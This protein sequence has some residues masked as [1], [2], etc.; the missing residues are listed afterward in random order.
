MGNGQ[1]VELLSPAGNVEGFY[2]AVHAGADAVYLAGERFGARAYARNFTTSE[3]VECIRYGHL[4]GRKIYLT[5]NTLLKDQ[6]LDGLY[7]Y[8]RPVC[9]AG[10]DAVIVQ[11]IGVLRFVR[12]HFPGCKIHVSTQM[13]LCSGF[14]ASLLKSMGACRIVPARELCLQELV[15]LKRKAEVEVEAFV[16]GAMCYCY[17]GQCLFSSVLGARSGNRGR[18]AQPCRLPY[19]V[20]SKGGGKGGCYPLSLKD[21][22]TIEHLP[23]LIESGIDSFKIEGRMKKPEYTAGVTALYR[24]YIDRYYELRNKEGRR[25][26]AAAFR[27]AG[28]DMEALR[29]LYIRSEIQDGYYFRKGGREMITLDNPAYRGSDEE[30]LREIRRKYI[31]APLKLPVTL[32]AVFRTGHPA[33]VDMDWQDVRVSV[34]GLP[35]EKA[36][37]QPVSGENIRTQLGKLGDS[38]FYASDIKVSVDGDCFYPLKQMNELRRVAAAELEARILA[39]RGYRPADYRPAAGGQKPCSGKCRESL[40]PSRQ[41]SGHAFSVLTLPQ[42]EALLDWLRAHPV[43]GCPRIYIDGDLCLEERERVMDLARGNGGQSAFYAALPY[44]VREAEGGYLEKLCSLAEE[45]GYFEGYLVRSMDGLGFLHERG[46]SMAYRAD[47]GLYLWNRYAVR[48]MQSRLEGFCLPYELN[49]GEQRKLGL[50]CEAFPCEKIVYGRIPMMITAN[51]LLRTG[52]HCAKET[53][54]SRGKGDGRHIV[55]LRDRYGMEFPV[56]ADCKH[57][58]NIIYNSVPLSLH[59]KTDKWKGH[60]DLRMDFT[61]ESPSEVL[62]VLDCFFDGGPFPWEEYTNVYEKRG[63]E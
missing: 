17:S 28:E 7:D 20:S 63:V 24:R 57:C 61:L 52:G 53:G 41:T 30:Q 31:D 29:S 12:E 58:M 48:E 21:M 49:A 45:D 10:V 23:K 44:I 36:Q 1:R 11:D 22:C 54:R 13:T 46:G 15:S 2:G 26:A 47:A 18:C 39:H 50:S 38:P 40:S 56:A 25:E 43:D 6:E 32:T 59:R 8:L 14:G 37:K 55:T 3:L 34:C 33:R 35:V 5:V 27:V 4:L 51:C 16:H 42:L 62:R 19:S 9:E 60:V